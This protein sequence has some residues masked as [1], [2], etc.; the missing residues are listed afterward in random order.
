MSG[1]DGM[2]DG[3]HEVGADRVGVGCVLQAGGEGRNG[4]VGVVAS[5]VEPLID[6][7]LYAAA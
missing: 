4:V 1:F 6:P 7:V 5:A 3:A 2:V